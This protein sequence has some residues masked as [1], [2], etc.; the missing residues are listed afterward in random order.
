MPFS[1]TFKI[2]SFC[3]AALI[4]S[5]P[6]LA[7][8]GNMDAI[9]NLAYG[10][11]LYYFFQ[12][13]YFTAITELLV[14]KEQK[15][16]DSNSKNAELLL[17]GMYLSYGLTDKASGIFSELLEK[18][19]ESTPE[20]VRDKAFYHLGKYYYDRNRLS[21]AEINLS[22]IHDNLSEDKDAERL[23]M[24]T[25]IYLGN[26]KPDMAIQLLGYFSDDSVLK[27]YAEY[28]IGVYL[29]RNNKLDDAT[30]Y[31]LDL[32]D[33]DPDNYE[34]SILKDK[35]NISL[36]YAHLNTTDY[37]TANKYLNNVR[38]SGSQT[39]YALLGLGVAYQK[40]SQNDKAI[41][42]WSELVDHSSH[43]RARDEA[44]LMLS[45]AYEAQKQPHIALE[46]YSQAIDHY[47]SELNELE[48]ITN[49]VKNG[50]FMRKL[51]TGSLGIEA[52]NISD[53]L[54]K[55]DYNTNKYLG[56]LF[57]SH[58]FQNAVKEMQELA[59]LAYTLDQWETDI[60]ALRDILEE[61]RITYNEKI[62]KTDYNTVFNTAHNFQ[63]QRNKLAEEI[64]AL[65]QDDTTLKLASEKER[66]ALDNLNAIIQA[67]SGAS[68]SATHQ[69]AKFLHGIVYW[70]VT[71]DYSTRLW[72]TKKSFRELDQAAGKMN[73]NINNLVKLWKNAPEVHKRHLQTIKAKEQEITQ[74]RQEIRTA[75]TD[76]KQAIT[77]MAMKATVDYSDRI[78]LY[79]DRALFAKARIYD[80]LTIPTQKQ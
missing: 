76:Q 69:K 19:T 74:L 46:H 35:A 12:D 22:K 13:K 72:N 77:N 61:K 43:S 7:N 70:N 30:E 79:H 67:S 21:D 31:I 32:S 73:S 56:Q 55:L 45:R 4:A 27:Y 68:N 60:P 33:L 25:N 5:N 17:G 18:S 54:Q 44:M 28:N 36:A 53:T 34:E 10:S 64:S 29:I 51:E 9:D 15:K 71:T 47:S 59:Y 75:L 8:T 3:L 41:I 20:S 58:E 42:A 65:E 26:G 40:T 62:S 23:L 39:A 11:S 57:T 63:N 52:T 48:K 6:C 16:L 66:I 1:P 38:L 2:R 80:Y 78:K 24:L 49:D 37:E 50:D 14:A